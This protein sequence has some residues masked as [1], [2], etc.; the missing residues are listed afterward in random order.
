MDEIK[1]DKTYKHLNNWHYINLEK[2]Q[3]YEK[4]SEANIVNKLEEA[5]DVIKNRK[6]HPKSEIEFYLKVIF[7]LVGDIH[8]P[9]HAGYASDKGGNTV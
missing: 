9:L 5:I 6:K 7:H 8:Q 3:L 4:N 2:N 1:S